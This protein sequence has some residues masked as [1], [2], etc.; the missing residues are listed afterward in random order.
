MFDPNSV[1]MGELFTALRYVGVLVTILVAG[2]KAH[3][4]I[5]PMMEFLE[6]V[7]KLMIRSEKHMDAMEE[8][9]TLLLDNHLTHI[10]ANVHHFTH[11]QV[12]ATAAEQVEYEEADAVMEAE[13]SPPMDKDP[14]V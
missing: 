14:Q 5:Q 2:W 11:N 13:G 4:T 1:T 9:M 10:G 3:A 8:S 12:R 7:K 6:L